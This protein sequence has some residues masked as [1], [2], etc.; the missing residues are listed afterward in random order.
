MTITYAGS[1][2]AGD[3]NRSA[4]VGWRGVTL[5]GL[6]GTVAAALPVAGLSLWVGA[7]ASD[8]TREIEAVAV[9]GVGLL[10]AV[11]VL[12]AGLRAMRRAWPGRPKAVL[13]AA[14]AA[15]L[16]AMVALDRLLPFRWGLLSCL[17][18]AAPALLVAAAVLLRSRRAVVTAAVGLAALLALAAP[19]R[20]LQQQ[21]AEREWVRTSGIPSRSLAQVVSFPGMR[22]DRYVWDGHTLTAMFSAPV[23]PS[24][25]WLAAETVRPGHADPCGP[26]LTADGDGTRTE[27]L[28]C[29]QEAPGLWYRGDPDDAVGYVLQRS[30]L[31]ITVTGGVWPRTH[32]AATAQ[33]ADDRAALRR[34]VL[35]ARTAT[36]RDLWTR[37]RPTRPT[38][39]S[40]VLL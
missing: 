26:V 29:V 9:A 27:T 2:G 30:G 22:Q 11:P 7:G 24:D 37:T 38:L 35:A 19:V 25:A 1:P 4:P 21:V 10:L 12:A 8:R 33:A 13:A 28:D 5:L 34:T 17:L 16:A 40:A 18:Y 39:L 23:G 20:A 31:T 36:T 14:F 3:M 15:D 6:A 32:R